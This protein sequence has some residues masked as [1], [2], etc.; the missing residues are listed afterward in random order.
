MSWLSKEYRWGI[1]VMLSRMLC[2]NNTRLRRGQV[3]GRFIT[4]PGREYTSGWNR[5]F[6]YKE[7]TENALSLDE[8]NRGM[9]YTETPLLPPAK[10]L[11]KLHLGRQEV[12]VPR[13][14]ASVR[15]MRKLSWG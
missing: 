3:D 7:L 13:G 14:R 8:Q 6:C 4:M 15:Q 1:E 5:N 2:I 10:M 11:Q 12:E 9:C